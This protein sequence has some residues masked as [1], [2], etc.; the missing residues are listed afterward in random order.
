MR[1]D[2]VRLGIASVDFEFSFFHLFTF[3]HV[4]TSLWIG[5]DSLFDSILEPLAVALDVYNVAVM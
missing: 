5:I 1:P 4:V 2:Q 3:L